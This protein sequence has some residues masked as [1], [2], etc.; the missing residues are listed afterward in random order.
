MAFHADSRSHPLET[1]P[2]YAILLSLERFSYAPHALAVI[3][4]TPLALDHP[5]PLAPLL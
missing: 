3:R 5:S 2:E 4:R 1:K